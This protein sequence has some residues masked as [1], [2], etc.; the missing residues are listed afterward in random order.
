MP[1]IT[2]IL[3]FGQSPFQETFFSSPC[4]LPKLS[5]PESWTLANLRFLLL[6]LVSLLDR[7]SFHTYLLENKDLLLYIVRIFH[8]FCVRICFLCPETCRGLQQQK[9]PL[10]VVVHEKRELLPTKCLLQMVD[11]YV[12][13]G[14]VWRFTLM[15]SILNV[16]RQQCLTGDDDGKNRFSR[17]S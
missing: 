10:H 1:V 12:F 2:I 4:L 16:Q 15:K 17:N 14:V 11:H 5:V 6:I 9:Q 3:F 13:D 8:R 7:V